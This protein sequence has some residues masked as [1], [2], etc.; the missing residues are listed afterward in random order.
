MT[1]YVKSV[2]RFGLSSLKLYGNDTHIQKSDGWPFWPLGVMTSG[3][4]GQIRGQIWVWHGQFSGFRHPYWLNRSMNKKVKECHT[5][6]QLFQRQPVLVVNEFTNLNLKPVW[7]RLAWPNSFL[8]LVQSKRFDEKNSNFWKLR[9][10]FSVTCAVQS[11]LECCN[12]G[13]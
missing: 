13:I 3:I 2:V 12:F 4:W 11:C 7:A 9:N 6:T 1:S 10:W 8:W 5:S